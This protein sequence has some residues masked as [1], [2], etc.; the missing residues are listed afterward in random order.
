MAE[1]TTSTATILI[2]SIQF[3]FNWFELHSY[4]KCENLVLNLMVTDQFEMND[5]G[6]GFRALNS[7]GFMVKWLSSKFFID[8]ITVKRPWLYKNVKMSWF[9]QLSFCNNSDDTVF[10]SPKSFGK[11]DLLDL[12]KVKQIFN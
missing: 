4:W 6:C 11:Y 3:D 2:F 7:S 8:S 12:Q 1:L 5:I 9:Q 10:K